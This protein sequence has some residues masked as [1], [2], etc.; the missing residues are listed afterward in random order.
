MQ[1]S[2]IK[3]SLRIFAVACIAGLVLAALPMLSSARVNTTTIN[4]VNNSSR[5]IRHVYLSHVDA[6]DWSADQLNN[7][8]IGA[9]QSS[10]LNNVSWDASQV[11]VIGEDQDGCFAST[12]VATGGSVTWTIT[13]D[14]PADCG[15]AGN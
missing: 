15:G 8:A 9:N 14:T 13:N 2:H 12:A 1:S 3:H 5:E 6:D 4:I 7:S 10:A 11:K